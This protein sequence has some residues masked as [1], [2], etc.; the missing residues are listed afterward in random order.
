M[1]EICED[2]HGELRYVRA[3]Q[4]HSSGV[5]ISPRLMNYVMIP[6]EGNNSSTTWVEHEIDTPWQK[7]G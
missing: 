4:G 7:L 5:I 2:E 6:C 3:I 1:F